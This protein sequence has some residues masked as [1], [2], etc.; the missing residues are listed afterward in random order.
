MALHGQSILRGCPALSRR[1]AR[2]NGFDGQDDQMSRSTW[3]C[4]SDKPRNATLE[5]IIAAGIV[6]GWGKPLLRFFVFQLREL[7]LEPVEF[8]ARFLEH[9]FLHL[10]LVTRNKIQ[11]A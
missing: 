2:R 10:E 11:F 9:G 3:M 6:P 4:E 8:L 7:Y 5:R 1:L